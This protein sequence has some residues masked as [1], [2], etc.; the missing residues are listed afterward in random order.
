M[1]GLDDHFVLVG[2]GRLGREVA[3]G[4]QH[5]RRHVVVIETQPDALEAARAAGLPVIEGD[6]SRDD[7]LREA[8]I[9]S[10]SGLAVATGS[11]AVNI[12]VTLSA[13]QLN[14]ELRILCRVDGQ[15]AA[16]KARRAGADDVFSP[17]GLGGTYM[18]HGLL[19]PHS[20]TFFQ[21]AMERQHHDLAMDDVLL[22]STSDLRGS[23]QEL[24]L[25]E[26]FGVLLV[27]VRRP[28]GTLE[29]VPDSDTRLGPD[30]VAIVVGSPE[31]IA[32]F[33]RAAGG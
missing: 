8:R 1:S 16:S 3:H 15:E 10:A 21:L 11:N 23:L 14:P 2:Y 22:R 25:R 12:L 33:A 7:V 13:R 9:A 19:H 18:A 27:G 31:Q 4:L 5:G 28:D 6:G 26:R 20:N 24:R 17:Y 29:S 32:A 30:D